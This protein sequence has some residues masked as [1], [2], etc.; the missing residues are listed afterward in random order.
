MQV[1]SDTNL[2]SKA[3]LQNSCHGFLIRC[4]RIWEE[5]ERGRAVS[6]DDHFYGVRVGLDTQCG[7]PGIIYKTFQGEVKVETQS[8]GVKEEH[9]TDE[10]YWLF[11]N[12]RGTLQEDNYHVMCKLLGNLYLSIVG[13]Q[14][15]PPSNPHSFFLLWICLQLLCTKMNWSK[16][17]FHKFH[18]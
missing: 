2:P 4:T 9:T 15:S 10:Q 5:P 8:I 16:T 14:R 17:S 6:F 11:D 7:S 12:D 18:Q 1:K 13:Y 3:I